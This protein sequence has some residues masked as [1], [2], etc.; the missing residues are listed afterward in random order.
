M[1]RLAKDRKVLYINSLG[2]RIPSLRND[3]HA[4]KKIIRK[5]RSLCHFIRKVDDKM[6]VLSP[7]SLPLFG[8]D[9]GRKLNTFLVYL[10]VRFVMTLLGIK[11]SVFYVG[12]PPALEVVKKLG[13]KYLIYERTD[14]FEEMPGANSSYVASLDKE[15]TESSDLVLYVN[16]KLLKQGSDNNGNSLLI[17]HGVDFDLFANAARSKQIPEDIAGISRPII[18]LYG[19]ISAKTMD[20][21]LLEHVAEKLPEMSLVLIGPVSADV[22]RLKQ[23]ENVF[24]LGQKAY[25]QI[26]HYGK[27]FDIFIMPW[28]QNKWIEYCNPVKIKEY[29]ALG[30]PVVTTYYPEIEPYADVVYVA[31]SYEAFVS[32]ICMALEESDP[33]LIE[34]RRRRV[35][36]ETWDSKVERIKAFIEEDMNK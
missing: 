14:L 2:V 6:Y 10:Q 24:F 21:T 23:F 15:L 33:N 36:Q 3:R 28:N 32:N 7:L 9:F 18:G 11:K 13:G 34:E 22:S 12:C 30:K 20:L 8:N 4:L 16:R 27:A 19:D 29:L 26:P 5:L 35:Q 25:E 1:K 31:D 17:G